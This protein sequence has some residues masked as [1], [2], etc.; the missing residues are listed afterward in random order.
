MRRL[1]IA[2]MMVVMSLCVIE[3][4]AVAEDV[5]YARP[6]FCIRVSWG[7]DVVYL[8]GAQTNEL[9]RLVVFIAGTD[10]EVFGAVLGGMYFGDAFEGQED[11]FI[12]RSLLSINRKKHIEDTGSSYTLVS[13]SE[14][15]IAGY[16][17]ITEEFIEVT[18]AGLRMRGIQFV[19][20]DRQVCY[21]GFISSGEDDF[22]FC[23]DRIQGIIREMSA[24]TE[25]PS[26]VEGLPL[27]I[28][29]DGKTIP[30]ILVHAECDDSPYVLLKWAG[31]GLLIT[32]TV[33]KLETPSEARALMAILADAMADLVEGSNGKLVWQYS[34]L[35]FE[36]TSVELRETEKTKHE[37]DWRCA[38]ASWTVGPVVY[39]VLYER[40]AFEYNR[41]DLK[42]II[43]SFM[44]KKP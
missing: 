22:P 43:A 40:F 12:I 27:A 24:V 21:S 19:F 30:L 34:F 39:A 10:Q 5:F 23:K 16:Y 28:Q 2:S 38:V 14:T 35:S 6:P 44:V 29:L 8:G 33:N 3:I 31:T 32:G 7:G 17:G 13:S 18:S 4:T 20:G 11:E 25:Y 26:F 36:E 42:R 41:E 1:V 9:F 15:N 37:D